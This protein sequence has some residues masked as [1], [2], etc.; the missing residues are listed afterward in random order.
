M[1]RR[2]FGLCLIFVVLLASCNRTAEKKERQLDSID[3]IAKDT[4]VKPVDSVSIPEETSKG[5]SLQ[6][7][8]SAI[9][10]AYNTQDTKTLNQYIDNKIGFYTIYRPGVQEIYVHASAID[11]NHPIPDY[12]P[13]PKSNF[14]GK[15][16]FGQLPIY[17]CGKESWNKK[18]LFCNNKQHPTALSHTAKYMNEIL[19]SKISETEMQKLKAL[20][21]KSYRVILAEKNASFVFHIT[22]SGDKWI[23]TVIDRAY[24]GCDA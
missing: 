1:L 6:Q 7:A 10:H 19:E 23:L 9:T 13:Y 2:I 21:A 5:E 18:G 16:I 22:Q 11:F 20:E 17:D 14:S 3:T 15:V 12:Y 4:L 8:I 24:G